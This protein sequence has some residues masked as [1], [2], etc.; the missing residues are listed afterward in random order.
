[1]WNL[2][3]GIN[4]VKKALKIPCYQIAANAGVDANEVVNRVLG[5]Q[6]Q[7]GYDAMS[8]KFVDMIQAGII[9]P[10]KVSWVGSVSSR[11]WGSRSMQ[12]KK[13]TVDPK[14]NSFAARY[15]CVHAVRGQLAVP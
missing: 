5:E 10:T 11:G 13:R 8:G 4:I 7:I 2:P 14:V 3:S 15:H 1:M 12:K 6:T 9:D